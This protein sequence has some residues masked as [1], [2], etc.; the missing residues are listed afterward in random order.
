MWLASISRFNECFHLALKEQ[1]D[2]KEF[3]KHPNM[4]ED[5][6]I[7]PQQH[8]IRLQLS[9]WLA[10]GWNTIQGHAKC[11]VWHRRDLYYQTLGQP[12]IK[13]AFRAGSQTCSGIQINGHSRPRVWPLGSVDVFHARVYLEKKKQKKRSPLAK[14]TDNEFRVLRQPQVNMAKYTATVYIKNK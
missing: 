13:L 7:F 1:C 11:N 2:K 12:N 10:P 5:F 14:F 8:K 4:I 3:R 9:R 6:C